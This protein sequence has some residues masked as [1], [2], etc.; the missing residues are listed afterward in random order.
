MW[1]DK[2]SVYT[3]NGVAVDG[4]A[5]IEPYLYAKGVYSC[6]KVKKNIYNVRVDGKNNFGDPVQY[7]G[8]MNKKN[9][10]MRLSVPGQRTNETYFC[11]PKVKLKINK[12]KKK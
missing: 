4:K 7:N 3:F 2:D 5:I 9:L 8:D 6:E 11:E 1:F 10:V 12:K